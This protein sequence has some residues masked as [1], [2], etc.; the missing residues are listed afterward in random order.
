MGAMEDKLSQQIQGEAAKKDPT[1]AGWDAE[2]SMVQ[3]WLVI[4][5]EKYYLQLAVLSHGQRF[6]GQY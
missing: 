5:D 6:M 2:N 4:Y 1:Y 3:T